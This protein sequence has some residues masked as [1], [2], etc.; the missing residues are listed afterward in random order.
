MTRYHV[1]SAPTDGRR[2]FTADRAVTATAGA[3]LALALSIGVATVPAHAAPTLSMSSHIDYARVDGTN[4]DVFVLNIHGVV[5]MSQAA[6]QDSI[7]H[8]YTIVLRYWGDDEFSDDLL[9]GPVKPQTVSAAADGL[10]FEHSLTIS[11]SLLNEDDVPLVD[12]AAD[13]GVDEIY[14][15]SRLLDPSGKT[16]SLAESNRLEQ[17]F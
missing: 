17:H 2:H 5:T 12:A 14:V 13:N 10:H 16:I 6:A 11:H 7:N 3:A 4:D 1:K 9:A 8:G 15:G